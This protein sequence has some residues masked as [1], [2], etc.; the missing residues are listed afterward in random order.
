MNFKLWWN[1]LDWFFSEPCLPSAMQWPSVGT[2]EY[3]LDYGSSFPLDW[4]RVTQKLVY[5]TTLTPELEKL[6]DSS[7]W[8]ELL[9]L[10]SCQPCRILLGTE[11]KRLIDDLTNYTELSSWVRVSHCWG[12]SALHSSDAVLPGLST[13]WDARHVGTTVSL[14][15]SVRQCVPGLRC[16]SPATTVD[17]GNWLPFY[18]TKWNCPVTIALMQKHKESHFQEQ[19]EP[20]S[21]CGD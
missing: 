21:L 20:G 18:N 5:W 9:W 10:L 12:W 13:S 15:S 19:K 2:H 14:S 7:N 4:A 17:C 11:E 1:I 16:F 8:T 3:R 6:I